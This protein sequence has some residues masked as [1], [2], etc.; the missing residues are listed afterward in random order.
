MNC[1]PTMWKGYY[2]SSVFSVRCWGGSG[3]HSFNCSPLGHGRNYWYMHH[4]QQVFL[5]YNAAVVLLRKSGGKSEAIHVKQK[6]EAHLTIDME[7]TF[8]FR[9]KNRFL[10]HVPKIRIVQMSVTS[11]G[12]WYLSECAPFAACGYL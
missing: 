12:M 5:A 1:L 2:T 8:S 4:R 7:K 11:S 6:Y 10:L 9:S 3:P